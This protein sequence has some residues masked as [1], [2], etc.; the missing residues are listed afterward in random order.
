[1]KEAVRDDL[2]A[3][4]PQRRSGKDAKKR[5]RLI[6]VGVGGWGES[7]SSI[8]RQSDDFD[9][10]AYVDVSRANLDAAS[11][12]NGIPPERCFQDLSQALREVEADALLA[13]VPARVHADTVITALKAGLHVL[14]EKP[15]ADTMERAREVVAAADRYRR[16]VM[17]SQNY[18]FRRQPRAIRS[19]VDDG[20]AGDVGYVNVNFHK[21]PPFTGIYYLQLPEPILTEM[22]IHHFDLMRYT[23]GAEPRRLLARSWRPGWSWFAGNPTVEILVE[24]EHGVWVNYSGSWVSRGW[25][26]T[27]TG[28]WR[29]E[30]SN[31][32]IHWGE[33]RVSITLQE[34]AR[35]FKSVYARGMIERSKDL[36]VELPLTQLEDR[37]FSLHEFAE[38]IREGREPE[39]NARDNLRSLAMVFAA[40]DSAS[41]SGEWCDVRRYLQ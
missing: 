24:M 12:R 13:V 7:W 14:V 15:L 18:R 8:A 19:I 30:C 35:T 28:D 32:E 41:K 39:T 40:V 29:I 5:L 34:P 11:G 27:W 38:S 37:W 25:E 10:V 3:T 23:L 16:S 36:E 4:H 17:V 21:A 20:F 6:Q 2:E 31:G 22:V 26:T 33:G 9:V 1:V